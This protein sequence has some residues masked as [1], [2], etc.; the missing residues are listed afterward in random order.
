MTGLFRRFQFRP[1]LTAAAL[2]AFAI[3]V[4]LGSWQLHR[5][6]WKNDLVAK[7]EARVAAEPI[8][9][10]EAMQRHAAG[11]DMTYTP[12]FVEGGYLHDQEA[13]VFGTLD[14]RAGYY[15]FTPVKTAG[16]IVY[17]NRGFAPQAFKDPAQRDDARIAPEK[18]IVGLFRSAERPSGV[19]ALVRPENLPAANQWHVRDPGAF[20]AHAGLA[21]VSAAYLDSNGAESAALWPRGGTTRVDFNNRH[22][23]YA[24]TWFGLAA[25]LVGVWFFFSLRKSE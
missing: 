22:M 25:T 21:A 14:G 12:V 7:I 4:T 23:E 16:D 20:A 10:N 8:P 18:P 9:F 19:A 15:I 2:S 6:E 3:L 1:V 5:L 24:L 13:H 11:E 17:V